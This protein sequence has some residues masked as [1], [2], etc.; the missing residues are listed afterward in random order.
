MSNTAKQRQFWREKTFGKKRKETSKEVHDHD[1]DIW[2]G[3]AS[4]SFY[5]RSGGEYG[6]SVASGSPT[7]QQTHGSSAVSEVTRAS[8]EYDEKTDPSQWKRYMKKKDGAIPNEIAEASQGVD[9]QNFSQFIRSD[10]PYT[11]TGS[12]NGGQKSKF[13]FATTS[14]SM[15]GSGKVPL[16]GYSGMFGP[17]F[18]DSLEEDDTDAN[19]PVK[20]NDNDPFY[21]AGTAVGY[22]LGYEHRLKNAPPLAYGQ[23]L[24][25]ARI[26][27]DAPMQSPSQLLDGF[28]EEELTLEKK[29][30]KQEYLQTGEGLK[31]IKGKSKTAQESKA[32]EKSTGSKLEKKTRRPKSLRDSPLNPKQRGENPATNTKASKT[33][34]TGYGDLMSPE[35]VDALIERLSTGT[36]VKK[37]R[38]ELE[39]S[40]KKLEETHIELQRQQYSTEHEIFG[41]Y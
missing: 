28:Q 39:T 29:Q 12:G 25:E 22:G 11:N 17:Q 5:Q 1:T 2:Q 34:L 3:S 16:T 4:D 30:F 38:K 31:R 21:G 24:A 36:H 8:Y 26:R 14:L 41:D 10:L 19:M 40:R 6:I 35:E 37:L 32:N 18:A 27:G 13:N 15:I 23:T 33:M 20:F 9:R 7:R